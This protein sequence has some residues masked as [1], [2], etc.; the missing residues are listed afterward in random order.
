M[1]S[2]VLQA[3]R[4]AV[5]P[6]NVSDD[7]A[8]C[9]SY[10]WN[11]GLGGVPKPDRL[12]DTPPIAVVLPGSADEVRKVVQA[13][14]KYGVKFKP[15]STG[16]GS[17][18]SVMMPNSISMDLRRM[19]RIHDI[20]PKNKV[21]VIDPYVTA[22]QL[23][24]EAMKVGLNCHI[25]GA[26][27]THSPLASSTSLFGIGITGTSTGNNVRNLLGLEWI[28]PRGE[29]LRVGSPVGGRGWFTDEGPGPGF[30]GLIRGLVGA[31][32][33]LGV[34]TRI[35]YKLYPWEGGPVLK[36]CGEHP[37]IGIE[38]P[39]NFFVEHLVWSS[40]EEVTK[41]SYLINRSGIAS[42]LVRIPPNSWGATLTRTN[43]EFH[44]LINSD[45]VP[46]ITRD[47]D[48]HRCTWTILC[49]AASAAERDYKCAVL[50]DI[51]GETNG[52]IATLDAQQRSLVANMLVTSIFIPRVLR[53][54]SAL[55][56]SFG[57]LESFSALPKTMKLGE[58]LLGADVK[59]GGKLMQ[60]SR[61]EFWSWPS[62]RRHLWTENAF[63]YDINDVES[64]AAVFR[65]TLEQ[66]HEIDQRGDVGVDAFSL[67]PLAE[68]FGPARSRAR[69]W[70]R[71]I[72]LTLD[73]HQV[74]E[75][76]SYVVRAEPAIAPLWPYIRRI[77]FLP[78]VR[79]ILN[80]AMRHVAVV[81]L[82]SFMKPSKTRR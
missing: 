27:L 18:A 31:A 1:Q 10:S 28:S 8:I 73:N 17:F 38:L 13:C 53:P 44:N 60:G 75:A 6:E 5:G 65:Y 57:L 51:L 14:I 33:E 78:I 29:V 16:Y 63:S 22:G 46:E 25:V 70:M 55:G 2:D 35:G 66:A 26:G 69:L 32:G 24:A 47:D 52:R 68:F 37:Q 74:Q 36:R 34:F 15:H 77:A 67:G 58:K 21:A 45:R 50:Q 42:I 30:R 76:L 7:P 43:N 41:A 19:N 49:S 23:Q 48:A 79:T 9:T 11:A 54:S 40:W 20:D 39:E 64:R 56:T 59:P 12:S 72:K 82:R 4:D 80:R 61:E 62:E 71:K 3:L 81:G